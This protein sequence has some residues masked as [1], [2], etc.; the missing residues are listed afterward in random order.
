MSTWTKEWPSEPN[1]WWWLY[2][3]VWGNKEPTLYPVQVWEI[4]NGK[5]AHIASGN[6]LFR[7]E[8]EGPALWAPMTMPDLPAQGGAS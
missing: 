4:A 2:A 1:T 7:N 6:L 5:R 8:L 3:R